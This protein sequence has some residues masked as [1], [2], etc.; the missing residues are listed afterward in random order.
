MK[1]LSTTL[2]ITAALL[3]VPFA[4][5]Q[6]RETP[7]QHEAWIKAQK[8]DIKPTLTVTETQIPAGT[9]SNQGSGTTEAGKYMPSSNMPSSGSYAPQGNTPIYTQPGVK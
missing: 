7:A 6:A 1:T 3:A 4:S 8:I 5:V 9:V 2:L